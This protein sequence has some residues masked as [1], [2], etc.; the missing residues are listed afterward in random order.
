VH[1]PDGVLS[2][3]VWGSLGVVGG[4]SVAAAAWRLNRKLEERH[5]PLLGTCGAFV[6]A[7]QMLNFPIAAGVSGHF[8][9]GAFV[10]MLLGPA[11][12]VIVLASVLVIQAFVFQDGG[13]YALGANVVNMGLLGGVQ[14]AVAGALARRIGRAKDQPP[15]RKAVLIAGFVSGWLS[16]VLSSIACGFELAA[17][18]TA[19]V[20][21]VVP[22][23][24]AVHAGIGIGEGAIT[25]AAL[26]VLH[27]ARPDLLDL[28]QA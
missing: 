23:L 6:F 7:A 1:I 10:G 19:P 2:P 14:G 8:V 11:S 16:C 17:S 24:A 13:P 9:G 26:S 4:L 12:A 3:P 18:G 20:E 22:L 27:A 25:A 5:V 15:S 21:K 28:E